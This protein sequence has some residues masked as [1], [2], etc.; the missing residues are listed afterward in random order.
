MAPL[1]A[2]GGALDDDD[3][4]CT[5]DTAS[6][7]ASP[8][9][10]RSSSSIGLSGFYSPDEGERK[11]RGTFEGDMQLLIDIQ[12]SLKIQF[13]GP[14]LRS[15]ANFCT[16]EEEEGVIVVNWAVGVLQYRRRRRKRKKGT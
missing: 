4:G 1:F 16:G 5:S 12:H 9:R 10:R 6:P 8:G 7:H 11:T 3:G 14:T 2:G 15:L 13:N